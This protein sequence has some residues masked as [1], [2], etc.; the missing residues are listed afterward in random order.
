VTVEAIPTRAR[1]GAVDKRPT[2]LVPTYQAEFA[3]VLP[4][5]VDPAAFVQMALSALRRDDK[6]ADVA[7]RNTASLIHALRDAARLGHMPGTENYY[8]TP[9]FGKDPGVV[10]I[11]GYRGVVERMYRSGAVESIKV[12]L[13]R[14]NDRFR[15]DPGADDRPHHEVD[16]FADRGPI[17][18]AYAYAVLRGGGISKVVVIG[19]EQIARA[20]ASSATANSS[21]SPWTTDEPAMVMKTAAHR[22]EPWVPTSSEYLAETLRARAIAERIATEAPLPDAPEVSAEPITADPTTGEVDPAE[23][24][25]GEQA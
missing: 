18:G 8:L 20:K 14:A 19:P 25:F 16:W 9:R 15:F 21:H 13:V 1:A 7:N 5:H 3:T 11:E 17:L 22:L 2:V 23:D 12:E 24:P 10:G 6:L 4:R